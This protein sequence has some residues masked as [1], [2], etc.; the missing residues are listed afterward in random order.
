M[1]ATESLFG[2]TRG[3]QQAML[4]HTAVAEQVST[5]PWLRAAALTALRCRRH[6]ASGKGDQFGLQRYETTPGSP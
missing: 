2:I 4:S 5:P 3:L 6:V 1:A